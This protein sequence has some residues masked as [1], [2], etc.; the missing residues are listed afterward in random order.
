MCAAGSTFEGGAFVAA[1][2]MRH[3]PGMVM[4][5]PVAGLRWLGCLQA[6]CEHAGQLQCG[7]PVSS[8]NPLLAA[9][10]N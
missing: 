1:V 8:V 10:Q 4:C 3:G 2:C 6:A 9:V 7:K 5:R